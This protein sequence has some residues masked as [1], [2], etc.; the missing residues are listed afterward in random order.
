MPNLSDWNPT[1]A[2]KLF[3]EEKSRC[4]RDVTT[5]SVSARHQEYFKGVFPE[6]KASADAETDDNNSETEN[7][8]D[9]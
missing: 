1:A 5:A 8:F 4:K 7:I 9:F 3:V 2:A 6:A